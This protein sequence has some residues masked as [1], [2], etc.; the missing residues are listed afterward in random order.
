MTQELLTLE[1]RTDFREFCV[2]YLVVHEINAIFTR[3]GIKRGPLPS[4]RLLKGERR[5]LVEKYYASL[6][7]HNETDVDT[8]LKVIGYMLAQRY[9]SLAPREKLCAMCE[10]AGLVV[11]GSQVY[12]PS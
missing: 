8:F 11:D 2:T 1:L 5:T 9:P 4:D 10:R 7:W 6:N 12:R 3:A